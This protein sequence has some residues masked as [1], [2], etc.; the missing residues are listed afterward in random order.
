M[1]TAPVVVVGGGVGGLA[2]AIAV[3]ARA[4]HQRVHVL[5]ASAQVGGKLGTVVIDGVACDT[6]PSLLTLPDV[7]DQVLRMGGS[8]LRAE[9]E[10]VTPSPAF[11]YHFADGATVDVHV[12]VEATR[13]AVQHAL[14]A[15]ARHDLDVFLAYAER[16]WRASA[17][18]FVF[19]DAPTIA[20]MVRWA[21][22]RPRAMLDVDPLSSMRGAIH[23]RVRSPHLRA[24]LLRYATYNGS[25]PRTAPATLNC[26]AHVELALGGYGVKG[27]MHRLVAALERVARGMGVDIACHSKV[28]RIDVDQQRVRGVVVNGVAQPALAVIVNA[29]VAHLREQLWPGSTSHLPAPTAP[30]MSG[31]T[32][33]VRA[34]RTGQRVA[35]EVYFPADY[36]AEFADIFNRQRPPSDPTLYVCAQALAH[37]GDAWPD[38]EP[39]F[40]MTNAPAVGQ[41]TTHETTAADMHQRLVARGACNTSDTVVWHRSPR[42]LAAQF[43]GS[44]GSLYGAASNDRRAAFARPRN[45]VDGV[46]G[47]YLASGS[48]HPGGGVPL[49]VQSGLL[50]AAAVTEI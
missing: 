14:G 43:P 13:D 50:A 7:I 24:L 1:T 2:A 46:G 34:R 32:A 45:R 6:G 39:L 16:I 4:P 19:R 21:L 31:S 47:L 3:R 44:R 42:Q 10:L 9:L 33:V 40:C 41:H 12:D 23:R 37:Q 28:D 27:G 15:E 36:D 18:D 48:A 5:E 17:P 22:T 49:C 26:I 8:S 29:D 35:H 30:S 38:D 25:D 11:R 20:T